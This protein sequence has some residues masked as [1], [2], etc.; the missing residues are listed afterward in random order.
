MFAVLQTIYCTSTVVGLNKAARIRRSKK[1]LS[2]LK[3]R[4]RRF[5]LF[6]LDTALFPIHYHLHVSTR[7]LVFP[8][9]AVNPPNRIIPI[10][11][12]YKAV[13]F[14]C[15]IFFFSI[16]CIYYLRPFFLSPFFI[17]GEGIDSIQDQKCFVKQP[18]YIVFSVRDRF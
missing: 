9:R 15:T 14:R 8:N 10:L 2:Q 1:R 4:L 17:A 5:A 7:T 3:K 12:R 18:Q 11:K 16:P 13:T 6:R